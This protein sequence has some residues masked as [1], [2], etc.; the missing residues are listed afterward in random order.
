MN[1]AA[2][3]LAAVTEYASRG[4]YVFPIKPG[5][6]TP[7]TTRG[8]KDATTQ[9][10]QLD[11]WWKQWPD[12][13]IGIDCG[14]SGLL[15]VDVDPRNGGDA[16]LTQLIEQNGNLPHTVNCKTGGGG[17]HYYF[18]LP[19]ENLR[20]ILRTGID[21][22]HDGGYVIAPPSDHESGGTYQWFAGNSPDDVEV[23]ELPEW[24]K[25]M[26]VVP[27]S[28]NGEATEGSN[29][30]REHDNGLRDRMARYVQQSQPA[31]EGE[32]NNAAFRLAGHLAAFTNG[33]GK[34]ATYD[35]ILEALRAWNSNNN[36]PLPDD[37]IQSCVRSGM[38][39][40]IARKPKPSK[41]VGGGSTHSP[42]RGSR[43]LTDLG[44][45][46]RFTQQHGGKVRYCYAWSKWL[47]W[48]G[49]RWKIDDQGEVVRLAKRTVRSIYL[50]A[51]QDEL[52]ANKVTKIVKWAKASERSERINA[53]LKLAQSE[54][55]LPIRVESLDSYPWLLNCENGTLDLKTG[56]LR[57]H[58]SEDY[59]TKI[60]PVEYPNEP[61]VDA[62]LWQTFLERI[63]NDDRDLIDF[64]Q[65]LI[66]MAMVGQVFEHVLP[67][68]Y[69]SGAN[70]KSVFLETIS[71][72]L[73]D[74]YSMKA[75]SSML[76]A[77]KNDRH[78]TELADLHGKRLVNVI[79]TEDGRRLAESLVKELTGGDSVRARRMREDFWQFKPSH[80]IIM[81]TN[82]KPIVRG[83]GG[84]IWRR[85]RL[86]PF[87]VV[88]PE[89]DRDVELTGKLKQEWP[90][91]MKWAIEGCLS[92]QRIGLKSP[93]VVTAAT[94]EYRSD[95]DILGEFIEERCK[96]NSFLKS[97]GSVLYRCYHDWVESRGEHPI[98][99][100]TF[101]ERLLEKGFERKRSNGIWYL[102][103]GTVEG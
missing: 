80:S 41:P 50:E 40:G 10:L 100:R 101:G 103:I 83:T 29:T 42:S 8:F 86:V 12:A 61:G 54:Q 31:T 38:D 1:T 76:M 71:G 15:V 22:K 48:D 30:T 33:D 39:K 52:P 81:C 77:S 14:R 89:E 85:L 68:F 62:D 69:G 64:V 84:A 93:D 45:A 37:E 95:M 58:R 72:L 16:N 23:A 82:H 91:I 97:K 60:A 36:P 3:T 6:K 90:A 17:E 25:G 51:G 2:T 78:P 79:E 99:S 32:R 13:N 19:D 57:E 94:T 102:G 44:N 55:P 92:W 87:S 75:P 43:P 73:G 98:G 34:G 56:I 11:I 59:L 20:S 26:V 24:L 96:T 46:E 65:R 70:G 7:L 63:F 67:I 28:S 35:A 88:I 9:K 74:D 18:R 27:V 49:R 5:A 66:G 53:L 47:V 21:I 4:W